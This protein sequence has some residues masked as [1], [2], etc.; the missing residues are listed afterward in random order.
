[1][2]KLELSPFIPHAHADIAEGVFPRSISQATYENWLKKLAQLQDCTIQ[3]LWVDSADARVSGIMV[4]PANIQAPLP[5]LVFN[6]GGSRRYGMLNV[7]SILILLAP[8]AQMGYRVLA[9]N[10]RGNDGSTGSDAFGSADVQDILNLLECGRRMP[11]YNG[12]SYMLGWSRG[13]MMTYLAIKHGAD[14][15]AASS[16]AGVSDLSELSDYR[17]DM[18]A[19]TRE[20]ITHTDDA[21]FQESLRDRSAVCWAEQITTPLQLHHGTA[22]FIVPYTH[23]S[24]LAAKLHCPHELHT[25]DN[26]DHF[27]TPERESILAQTHTWFQRF[28]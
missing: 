17:P 7:M 11:D 6:R 26:G 5:L 13:G 16:I 22:D 28:A 25:Y 2:L 15:L 14:V 1:M 23:S 10:Y 24:T 3:R 8:L 20:L 4:E 9:S 27:L 19:L 18:L 12:K 21:S